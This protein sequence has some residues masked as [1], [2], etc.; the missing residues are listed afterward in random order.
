MKKSNIQPQPVRDA[1]QIA[2]DYHAIIEASAGTGKTHTIENLVVALLS[3]G[4]V[5]GLDAILVVTFTEKAAGELKDRIRNKIKKSLE[6]KPS[7]IL[8]ISLD[9]FDSASIFTVHGFC[10]KV[11]QEYAFEN[12]EQFHYELIDDLTVYQKCLSQVMREIW[13]ERYGSSLPTILKVSQFP[14]STAG[15][16]SSWGKRVIEVAVMYQP[17]AHDTLIPQGGHDIMEEIRSME[18]SIHTH[19]DALLPLVGKIDEHDIRASDLCA[20]YA[21]LN[22]NKKSIPRR[23]RI[24]IAVLKLLIAHRSRKATLS[25]ISDFL[26]EAEI[27][28]NGFEE[29]NSNWNKP[30]ADF[31][32]KLPNLPRI[33]DI[34]EKL[35]DL[36]ISEIQNMLASNT[37]LELKERAA[38]YK[39]AKGLMSYD[40]MVNHVHSAVMDKTGT[41]KSVLQKRYRYAL[42]DEFQDTDMLQWNIFREVFLE[43][44]RNRLFIIGD[45]KQ[46][47]YGFRG[48]DINAYYTAR[49]D[50][51]SKYGARYYSLN[52]NRRSSPALINACNALF[53][54]GNWFARSAIECRP[55]TYPPDK[56]PK[57]HTD[58]GSLFVIECGACSG[59]EA[60]IK[61]ADFIVRELKAII[62][63]CP[64]IDLK[65]IAILVTKWKEA[66]TVEKALRRANIK[67]SYYKKE[68]LYQSKEALELSYLLA[69]I[70][71]PDDVTAR[72]KALISRLF[73]V[74]IH[75]L[76]YAD[77][78]P[79][80]HPISIFF[81]KL[82]SLAIRRKWSLLFQSILE[83][84]GILYRDDIEDHDRAMLN[85]RSIVQYLEI[86]A[87]RN[88]YSIEE[89]CDLLNSLMSG[90]GSAHESHNIQKIDLEQPGVQLLTIHA[91][92]GLQ[93]RIVFIAGGFTYGA[94]PDVWTYHDGGKKVFD[95][96]QKPSARE[97]YEREASGE[98]ERLFYVAITRARDRIYIPVYEPTSRARSASGILGQK[99]PAALKALRND[100]RVT[101][102]DAGTYAPAEPASKGKARKQDSPVAIP[103]PLFPDMTMDFLERKIN[104]ESFSGL[105]EKLF[106]QEG[107]EK[108]LVEYGTS[109]PQSGEDDLAFSLVV[110]EPPLR[111]TVAELPRSKETGLMLHEILE[112]IDFRHVGSA[113]TPEGILTDDDAAGIINAALRSHMKPYTDKDAEAIRD[114]T[115]K[116]IWNTLH[117][118]LN[119]SGLVLN[120][121]NDALREVEFYYPSSLIPTGAVPDI[122]YAEGFMHGFIDMIFKHDGRYYLADWK[123]NYLEEGYDRERLEENIKYMH[124]DLQIMIYSEALIRWLKLIISDYSYERHF[125][126][127]FYLYL[128]GMNVDNPHSGIYFCRP[129]EEVLSDLLQ[130]PRT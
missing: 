65:D 68:G 124:Y 43:S 94:V 7:D 4:K 3:Q 118:K 70:A 60:K 71:S 62:Q 14:G 34:L 54:N 120:G 52:D 80:D 33:I 104:V 101:W 126:G 21:C 100:G 72:K 110:T 75:T 47:I 55:S 26:S 25:D 11:I 122:S 115:L 95:L 92:K 111:V 129:K 102:L 44:E 24:I 35:R 45:P 1:G 108:P 113:D 38:E 79:S 42:V 90:G 99:L 16:A 50:M 82:V 22:I 85:Y 46:A 30:G 32:Q 116:I 64:G 78:L 10:N 98:E 61:Y 77:A 51:L 127:V 83:D 74:H 59:S 6:D 28:E 119:E 36:D 67:Y 97:A 23:I 73:N 53:S 8:Q 18:T 40:D 112:R 88:N 19:L 114:E 48:A 63:N 130:Q 87:Y 58:P 76:S 106:M 103:S 31:E 107:G 84:S 15:G 123:S 57:A 66:G 93:F 69:S 5:P 105:K 17:S 9:C 89:I 81:E 96:V 39:K 128:R 41:L 20:A 56:D 117:A 91:S 37:V 125:G 13:P 2:L 49:D 12:G 27:G 29:L 86:E 109:V 121:L